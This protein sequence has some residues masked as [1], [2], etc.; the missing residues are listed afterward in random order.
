MNAVGDGEHG[1]VAYVL[2][3]DANGLG[4]A[5]SLGRR[6]IEVYGL[7]PRPNVPGMRSRY[8]HPLVCPDSVESP[9][10][11]VR[12]LTEHAGR[13]GKGI[14]YPT[15]DAFVLLV[16]RH[17]KELSRNFRFNLPPERVIEMVVNKRLQY[18]EATRLGIPIPKTIY[19]QTMAELRDRMR[20][21][22]LPAFIKPCYPFQWYG[23]F[24]SKGFI[25]NNVQELVDGFQ[26]ALSMGIGVMVQE[27]IVGPSSSMYS[28][29][30]YVS[31]AGKISRPCVWQKL[32]QEPVDSGVGS[33]VRTVKEPTIEELGARLLR[34]V[35][36]TGIAEAEFKRDERDGRFK[37]IELN[38]RSWLQ[39]ALAARAGLDTIYLQ[40]LDLTGGTLPENGPCAEGVRWLDLLSDIQTYWVLKE[41][42]EL[43]T[44]DWIRSW[45]GAEVHAYGALDDLRPSILR[46]DYGMALAKTMMVLAKGKLRG[47]A[48]EPSRQ[49][50]I[51][52][53]DAPSDVH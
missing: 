4:V 14:L 53:E 19:P 16:S 10:S 30:T 5:R 22:E 48:R 1:V 18:E 15:T 38:A 51:S 21:I 29:A 44:K 31:Q 17:R 45:W 20:E 32:R 42:H 50:P 23:T 47:Q 12:M 7:D 43:T 34:G 46:Y 52:P 11:L 33:F 9:D 24:G 41:R 13:N 36:Y 49:G 27:F 28:V 6:G 39:N 2:G 37:L 40:Y 8:V 26:R 35:G 3:M 25:A